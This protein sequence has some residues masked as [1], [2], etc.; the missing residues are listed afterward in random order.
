M[1]FDK[2]S[3]YQ[4]IET[5]DAYGNSKNDY[6]FIENI[7]VYINNAHMKSNNNEVTYFTKVIQG[8]TKYNSFELGEK[9]KIINDISEYEI[10]SFIN[11]KLTQLQ[12][13][14]VIL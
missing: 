14:E 9:Y 10:I 5:F 12:L 8:V 13:T 3:L 4:L 2:Y 6:E 7:D 1:R 11:G